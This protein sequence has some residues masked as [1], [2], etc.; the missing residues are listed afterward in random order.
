[1]KEE[2]YYIGKVEELCNISKKTLRYY[3]KVGVLSPDKIINENGY[4]YYSKNN[5]LDIPIIKYYKQ[6]G[7]K[8]EEIKGILNEEIDSEK[9]VAF[10]S[11][12][13]S[14]EEEEK[15]LKLKIKS[16]K[17]WYSLMREAN[18]VIN[19]KCNDVSIKYIEKN[20]MLFLDQSFN[21]D[22]NKS[23]INI[24]FTNYIEK[25]ENAITG[26]VILKFQDY[27]EKIDGKCTSAKI[28][29]KSLI[30]CE[31]EKTYLWG[32]CMVAACYHIGSYENINETY[33]KVLIWAKQN[34]YICDS[35]CYERYVIDYW[36]CRDEKSF[37][38]EIL[39]KIKNKTSI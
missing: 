39:I 35:E 23:I 5:L 19:N 22:Y 28:I 18:W 32:D 2:M 31:E 8:L 10:R 6:S 12:I 20:E 3:D 7:F 36:T 24:E 21:Y 17:D 13:E 4:R 29:Q 1:M 16:I 9:E 34:K 37:V 27:K 25:I 14:L 11:K 30:K 38:T 15:K 26:P 33:E